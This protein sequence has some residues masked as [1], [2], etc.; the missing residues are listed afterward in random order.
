MRVRAQWP[1]ADCWGDNIGV[2]SL[3]R[4]GRLKY[5]PICISRDNLWRRPSGHWARTLILTLLMGGDQMTKMVWSPPISIVVINHNSECYNLDKNQIYDYS[6]PLSKE[7]IHFCRA[8]YSKL[9]G[10]RSKVGGAPNQPLSWFKLGQTSVW[11]LK[12][13]LHTNK[14]REETLFKKIAKLQNSHWLPCIWRKTRWFNLRNL[15]V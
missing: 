10:A 4:Y 3:T 1:T 7:S 5:V 13:W 12:K 2:G 8:K 11:N 9:R 15:C 14:N 6:L